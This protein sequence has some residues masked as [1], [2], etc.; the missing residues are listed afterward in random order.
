MARRARSPPRAEPGRD[1]ELLAEHLPGVGYRPP[2]AGYLAWLDCRAL[3]LGDDPA[4]VFLE[5]GR[6]ALSPG[7]P[8]GEQGRGFARLN[9]GTSSALLEEAVRR[10]AA[11]VGLASQAGASSARPATT[12]TAAPTSRMTAA[13]TSARWS[14]SP[15]AVVAAASTLS[16]RP[17]FEAAAA[18]ATG[19]DAAA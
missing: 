16:R 3:E 2:Q 14:P 19:L 5:R 17:G 10:M 6:V 9:F 8:F 11:A 18:A 7:P 13:I 1:L 15:N 12:E 4:A